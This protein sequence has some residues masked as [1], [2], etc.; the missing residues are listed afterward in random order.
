MFLLFGSGLWGCVEL[1][2]FKRCDSIF[3]RQLRGRALS[4]LSLTW[5]GSGVRMAGKNYFDT[6]GLKPSLNKLW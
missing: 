3:C 4:F 5:L 1:M 6:Q 2:L